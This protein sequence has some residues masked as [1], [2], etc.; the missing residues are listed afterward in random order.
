LQIGFCC[1]GE[2]P[3]PELKKRETRQQLN[4]EGEVRFSNFY[5]DESRLLLPGVVDFYFMAVHYASG[6]K[7][8]DILRQY[9]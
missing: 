8:S 9:A 7:A 2:V 1:R 3:S 4:N 5:L 6:W